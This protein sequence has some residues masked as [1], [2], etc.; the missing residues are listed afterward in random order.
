[1]T[2]SAPREKRAGQLPRVRKVPNFGT[3]AG[4]EAVSLAAQIGLYL[5]DWQQDVLEDSLG[6]RPDGTWASFEV[7]LVVP[8]QNGKGAIVEARELAGLFLFGERLI[9]HSA[10]EYKTASEAFLRMRNLLQESPEYDKLVRRYWQANGEQGIELHDGARLRYV[11]RSKGSGRGFTGDLNILD[12]TYAL[13][14]EEL[15][16][17][18]PTMS[19]KKNPQI[20]YTSTPPKDAAAVLCQI[21]KDALKGKSRTCYFE[22]S[23]PDD[24]APT[25]KNEDATD[26]D[27]AMWRETNPAFGIRISEEFTENERARLSDESFAI[28]RLGVW[29]PDAEG[30]WQVISEA[31]W[32]SGLDERSAPVDP[33]ALCADMTPDRKHGV[34]AIAG[35]RSDGL[36]HVEVIDIKSG[37]AWI[38]PRLV[39]LIKRWKPCALALDPA[40]P[41]G[42]ILPALRSS[43]R[44]LREESESIDDEFLLTPNVRE[45]AQAF[46]DF[47][48]GVCSERDIRHRG[49]VEL[50]SAL[51]GARTRPLGDALAWARANELVNISPLVAVTN[52]LWAFSVRGHIREVEPW[53]AF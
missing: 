1:M 39:T 12:E 40:G 36:R 44:E 30:A 21:R 16:A 2:I 5:D 7:G 19:A 35:R 18:L 42:S 25:P 51:Q 52:A 34:I 33:V 9:L 27:R 14:D 24:W 8:R 45:A 17:L 4:R 11:A 26:A 46:G 37:S 23:P 28:E 38:V 31:D 6:E 15:A 50:A 32:L 48:D 29:P 3:S 49:Q 22:W 41:I 43:L 47:Y 10:H 13:T 53:I 20:W